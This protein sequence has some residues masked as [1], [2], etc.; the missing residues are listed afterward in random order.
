MMVWEI[1]YLFYFCICNLFVVPL[2]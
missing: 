2:S 1:L